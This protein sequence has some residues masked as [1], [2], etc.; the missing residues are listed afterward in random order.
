MEPELDWS[1]W[2]PLESLEETED[3]RLQ[4]TGVYQ[5][6]IVRDGEP[7]TIPR[8]L[9]EDEQGLVYIGE[10][11]LDTRLC[12]FEAGIRRY[13]SHTAGKK[14][15][16][17]HRHVPAYEDRFG[18]HERECRW[19]QVPKGIS[20]DVEHDLLAR[21]LRKFGE[22]PPLNTQSPIKKG[23]DFWRERFGDA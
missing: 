1:D 18:G 15:W 2:T 17:L 5:V 10:G 12:E 21:Y 13:S 22:P 9:G 6:R 19:A 8:W 23:R 3:P 20:K 4:K 14:R 16:I 11:Q 7:V